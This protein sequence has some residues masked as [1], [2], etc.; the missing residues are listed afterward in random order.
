MTDKSSGKFIRER[1]KQNY[2]EIASGMNE[3]CGCNSDSCCSPANKDLHQPKYQTSIGY[4]N[5]ELTT[6]PISA[7]LNLGC[8]NPLSIAEIKQGDTVLDLGSGA[9]IDSF[10]AAKKIGAMGMVIGMDMTFPMICKA[11]KNAKKYSYNNVKFCLAEIEHLPLPDET[12]DVIISNC[13]INLSQDKY[14]VF[15]EAYRVLKTGGKLAISDVIATTTLPEE[16]LNNIS[17]VSACIAGAITA[18]QLNKILCEVGFKQI[19]MK[20][21][22]HSKD[23]ISTWSTE[24]KPEA[25]I[26]STYIKAQ[27]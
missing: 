26:Q 12:V 21:H 2:G 9:G 27:K 24:I 8:G 25:F 3:G 7:N 19:E 20:C 6:V 10:L 23:F 4:S 22:N 18:D 14:Q 17:M 15:K 1:I 11:H 16:I 5:Q 13:V